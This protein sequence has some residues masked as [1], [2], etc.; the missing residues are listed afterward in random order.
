MS[1]V[2]PVANGDKKADSDTK[3]DQNGEEQGTSNQ[4]GWT[5][6][7][8]NDDANNDSDKSDHDNDSKQ[9]GKITSKK[10]TISMHSDTVNGI[11]VDWAAFN[12]LTLESDATTSGDDSDSKESSEPPPPP[13]SIPSKPKSSAHR[14]GKIQWKNEMILSQK[15]VEKLYDVMTQQLSFKKKGFGCLSDAVYR[16]FIDG[17]LSNFKTIDGRALCDIAGIVGVVDMVRQIRSHRI[18]MRCMFGAQK[19]S[20]FLKSKHF[21]EHFGRFNLNHKTSVKV[22]FTDKDVTKW[23]K[24]C[25]QNEIPPFVL[26]VRWLIECQI[27]ASFKEVTTFIRHGAKRN[28]KVGCISSFK[29]NG[30]KSGQIPFLYSL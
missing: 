2:W 20:K 10:S 11:T 3:A 22:P 19:G 18:Q 17:K 16:N 6:P 23:V 21:T 15:T 12:R 8:G 5:W 13:F 30:N 9:N 1:W 4:I 14:N 26:L 24:V 7:V 29:W 28:H 25:S 27:V